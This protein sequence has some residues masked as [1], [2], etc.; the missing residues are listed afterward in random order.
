M[1]RVLFTF[2]V[3]LF[4]LNSHLTDAAVA[5]GKAEKHPGEFYS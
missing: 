4:H 1:F 3:V 2:V 5:M